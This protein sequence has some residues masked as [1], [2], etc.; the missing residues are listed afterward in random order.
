MNR[1][2]VIFVVGPTASG[3]TA[4]AVEIARAVG[5]EII[6]VDSRQVYR[7]LDIGTA[8]PTADEQQAARHHL[9]DVIDPNEPVSLGWFLDLAH[10][11]LRDIRQRGRVPIIVGGTGQWIR[12]LL[13]DW[14]VPRVPPDPALRRVLEARLEREGVGGLHTELLTR[15]PVAA[16]RIDAKNPRRVMRALEIALTGE[17]EHEPLL[18]ETIDAPLILGIRTPRDVLHERIERRVAAM[19]T[20]GLV[21]EVRGLLAA[22]W[23]PSHPGMSAI[24]YREVCGALQGLRTLEDATAAIASATRRLARS[25]GGWFRAADPRITWLDADDALPQR[26][27]SA[28]HRYLEAT[29]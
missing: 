26:A 24:G 8:K 7:Y 11:A 18:R 1:F 19:L 9:I 29:A 6:N 4:L 21:E 20:A 28:A 23:Q 22:G 12:A 10:V 5:G 15:D 16:A 17:R 27:L 25:Q 2:P 14:Q 3:K 13:E